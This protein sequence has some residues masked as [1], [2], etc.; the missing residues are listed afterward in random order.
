MSASA[1]GASSRQEHEN[2][3]AE[4]APVAGECDLL[5]RIRP[6]N[7]ASLCKSSLRV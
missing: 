2:P 6:V 3:T 5:L 7:L 4:L 1:Q